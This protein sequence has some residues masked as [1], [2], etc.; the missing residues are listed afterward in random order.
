MLCQIGRSFVFPWALDLTSP[1]TGSCASR[2][3]KLEWCA[4]E[5]KNL[6]I[7]H[8]VS[9]L[10]HR[11]PAGRF[12]AAPIVGGLIIWLAVCLGGLTSEAFAEPLPGTRGQKGFVLVEAVAPGVRVDLRYAKTHNF[13]HKQVYPASARCYLR[14]DVAQRVGRVQERL[15]AKGLGLKLLDCYRPL[16]VQKRFWQLVPDERYVANP[17][18]GSRHNRGAAVDLTLVDREGREQEMP[19]AFDDFSERA[20]RNFMALPEGAI[21][22][23]Q[24]LQ[25]AMVAE[26]FVPMPTEWWHFDAP[27]AKT[28]GLADVGFDQ[29]A[30]TQVVRPW[31]SQEVLGTGVPALPPPEFVTT[32]GESLRLSQD[33]KQINTRIHLLA[34]NEASGEAQLSVDADLWRLLLARQLAQLLQAPRGK[35][36]PEETLAVVP[37][38]L[39][40]FH[41]PIAC[42]QRCAAVPRWPKGD[43]P[44]TLATENDHLVFGLAATIPA[45]EQ[46]AP[47]RAL[48]G[49]GWVSG[50]AD[51]GLRRARSHVLLVAALTGFSLAELPDHTWLALP[52]LQRV[53]LGPRMQSPLP[54]TVHPNPVEDVPT[55]KELPTETA[56]RLRQLPSQSDRWMLL[57]AVDITTGLRVPPQQLAHTLIPLWRNHPASAGHVQR[58]GKQLWLLSAGTNRWLALGSSLEDQ[59]ILHQRIERSIQVSQTLRRF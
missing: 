35:A 21:A 23:R 50:P 45:E 34:R 39:R 6:T 19:T 18:K 20:H 9:Y 32:D 2:K 10:Y 48:P 58:I 26:G 17:Q 52:G 8:M 13:T 1:V 55:W 53:W 31:L 51:L 47:S 29:L 25:D 49:A 24:Q 40:A 3:T 14:L 59:Q 33:G 12:H 7:S 22:N 46:A 56:Q 27:D 30:Q 43:V 44:A 42:A 37:V 4:K 15:W 36:A 41:R 11:A 38:L 5:V 28:Y 54:P 16:R 57:G